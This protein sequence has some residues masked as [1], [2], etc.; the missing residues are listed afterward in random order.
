M[1]C[2]PEFLAALRRVVDSETLRGAETLRRL[3]SYLGEAS[4]RGENALKEYTVGIEALGRPAT[5]DTRTDSSVRVQAG[6]LRQKLD[7]YYTREGAS[8]P[9]RIGFPKGHYFVTFEPREVPS[10]SL[11]EAVQSSRRWRTTAVVCIGL[12]ALSLVAIAVLAGGRGRGGS[13]AWTPELEAIWRPLVDGSAPVLISFDVGIFVNAGGFSIRR[14]EVND[15]DQFA[16]SPAFRQLLAQMGSPPFQL[17]RGYVGSG[18]VYDAFLLG[19]LL[20]QQP[21][22]VVL[23]PGHELSWEDIR[24]H[25]LIF[26]GEGKAQPKIKEL[27]ENLDFR[28]T[29]TGIVNARPQPSDPPLGTGPEGASMSTHAAITLMPGPLS[30]KQILVLATTSTEMQWAAAEYLTDPDHAR[31]MV[32]RVGRG[33]KM[34]RA[35]QVVI[36]ATVRAGVPME[37]HYLTHHEWDPSRR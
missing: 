13:R 16:A 23:K 9:I 10:I 35:Y 3:L 32:R 15:A 17:N 4:L 19:R 14:S 36:Q 27:L 26:I 28:L 2:Q 1:E 25:H 11:D 5:Y 33:G 31:E 24:G 7:E 30:G 29:R 12:C 34:P 21:A 37:I 20:G 22:Q 18:N 6:K 8:D